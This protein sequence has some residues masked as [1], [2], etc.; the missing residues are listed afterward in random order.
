MKCCTLYAANDLRVVE[1]ADEDAPLGEQEVLV[2]CRMGGI[3]GS[4]LHY[5]HEGRVGNFEVVEPL[6]LGHEVAGEILQVGAAVTGLQAGQRVAVNPSRPCNACDYCLSGASNHCRHMRFFGSASLRPHV[7]GV[8]RQFLRV[9]ASQC[10]PVPA[11]L[12]FAE[13]AMGEPLAVALHAVQ[14]AGR[15]TGRSMLITGAGPIG[16]LVLLAA[17]HAGAAEVCVT[18]LSAAPLA[19][20]SRLGADSVIDLGKT[21]DGLAR[22]QAG[23]GYFDTVIECSGSVRAIDGAVDATRAG[24]TL[25]QVG[26]PPVGP[27]P[28]AINK[29]LAKEIAFVGSFRFHEEFDWAIRF[30]AERRIDVTPLMTGVYPMDEAVAAFLAAS[31]RDRHMKVHLEF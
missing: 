21:P 10:V 28:F 4:D 25:V 18:D 8:F 29:L 19:M 9:P 31:D 30:I 11:D 5:F 23:K 24:G 7:Q 2:R 3:C 1:Q 6:T 20:A 22:Y 27:Q 16:C 14:Q 17:R 13:A 15:V 26:F 12:P